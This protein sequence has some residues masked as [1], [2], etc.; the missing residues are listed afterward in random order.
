MVGFKRHHDS[1]GVSSSNT[2]WENPVSSCKYRKDS[3]ESSREKNTKLYKYTPTL[4]RKF[5]LLADFS[6]GDYAA[7]LS[8]SICTICFREKPM[9]M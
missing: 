5:D 8:V 4:A 7:L 3:V 1:D 6:W 9:M 2:D